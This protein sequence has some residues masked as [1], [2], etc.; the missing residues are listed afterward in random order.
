[1]VSV[2]GM[3]LQNVI[4]SQSG[5][6]CLWL[7]VL[8]KSQLEKSSVEHQ[9]RREIEIQSHLRYALHA[10]VTALM[11]VTLLC[12]L[13]AAVVLHN[14]NMLVMISEVKVQL[15]QLVAECLTIVVS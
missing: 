9:L 15:A 1:M 7:Q 14:G 3:P 6:H 4:V 11:A 13:D 12:R 8:F 10:A 2:N 5:R